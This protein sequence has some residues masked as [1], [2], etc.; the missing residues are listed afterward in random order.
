[1]KDFTNKQGIWKQQIPPLHPLANPKETFMKPLGKT[2]RI[3]HFD[4]TPTEEALQQLLEINH[5]TPYPA[6]ALSPQAMIFHDGQEEAF[7]RA[8]AS[9]GCGDSERT[10]QTIE[11][12]AKDVREQQ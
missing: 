2:M 6:T 1:M 10:R 7:P 3:A 8:I 9:G 11:T 5:D 12:S 4:K